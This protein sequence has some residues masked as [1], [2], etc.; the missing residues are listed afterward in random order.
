M[1]IL[2]LPLLLIAC[3]GENPARE[4]IDTRETVPAAPAAAEDWTCPMHTDVS[5]KEAGSC[6]KCGMPLV[7]RKK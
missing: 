2:W 4:R 7:P 1:R 5:A 3:A 6:P